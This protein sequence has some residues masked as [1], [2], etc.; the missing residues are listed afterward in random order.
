MSAS[1]CVRL[2]FGCLCP[3]MSSKVAWARLKVGRRDNEP[4][5]QVVMERIPSSGHTPSQG[6]PSCRVLPY[7]VKAVNDSMVIPKRRTFYTRTKIR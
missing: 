4:L 2:L 1:L 7:T 3:C 5:E 6:H